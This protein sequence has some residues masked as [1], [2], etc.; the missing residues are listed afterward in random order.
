MISSELE[1]LLSTRV[2]ASISQTIIIMNNTV[3][4]INITV[5][6]IHIIAVFM[7][8]TVIIINN[9]I[10]NNLSKVVRTKDECV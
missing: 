2:Q 7:H 9:S 10:T 5:V 6:L 8:Y 1:V 4:I 3:I